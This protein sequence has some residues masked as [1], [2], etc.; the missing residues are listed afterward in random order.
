MSPMSEDDCRLAIRK[1]V[2]LVISYKI[3]ELV[4]VESGIIKKV[5][6]GSDEIMNVNHYKE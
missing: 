5:E 3:T 2:D 6:I 1:N 4:F